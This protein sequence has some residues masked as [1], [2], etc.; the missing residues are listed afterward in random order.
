V[1]EFRNLDAGGRVALRFIV[2]PIV[3]SIWRGTDRFSALLM[4][5]PLL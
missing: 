3:L 2:S 5:K 1:K 4:F